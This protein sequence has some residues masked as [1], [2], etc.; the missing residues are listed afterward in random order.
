MPGRHITDSQRGLFMRTRQTDSTEVA[1]A[2][3]GFS[4]AS[5]Y[6]IA[7]DPTPPPDRR[8]SRGRRRADPLAEVFETEVVPLLEQSP[9]LRPV[10]VFRELMRRCPQLGPGVRRTLERRIRVWRAAH[11]PEKEVIFRQ[12]QEAGHLG[13]SDFTDMKGLGVLV[14]GAPLDHRLYHFR[15]PWSG[16]A[17]ARVVLGGESFSALSEGLQNALGRLGGAPREN[18]TDSLSA[19][20]RNLSKADAEDLTARYRE[21]C[22][23]YGMTPTRN[24][25]GVAHENGA[26]ESPHG[27]LKRELAD[28]LALR[29][30][31]DFGDLDA[32]RAFVSR[33]IEAANARRAG[34]I[35]AERRVL[36][37]LPPRRATDY[38]ETSV[39]VTSSGGFVLRK[40]FYTVPSRLIGHRLGVRVFDDR[41]ELFLG[42]QPHL[43]LPRG[44]RRSASRAGY[45]VNYRHVIHSLKRKPMA[46]LRSVYRDELF[47]REAYRRCFERALERGDERAAC[48]RA[49]RLLAL[50]HEANCEAE[51]AQAI[52]EDLRA[53]KLPD[54]KPLEDRFAPRCGT[55]PAVGVAPAELSGYAGLAGGAS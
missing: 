27:H 55:M 37:P 54:A 39:R 2:K 40:V 25:R 11:G 20:F 9:G 52:E 38:D 46:L 17:H 10:G 6:R 31:K 44:R 22:R 49:V 19:A 32:Y 26:I 21:V 15:L 47:P 43:T 1:A 18:R 8:Q 51:L 23:H 41:L 24:N 30:S 13:V 35:E 5:G 42:D 29:G 3:A 12:T 53:G 33:V 14:A 36:R 34:R 50:A 45:V 16:F 28:A 48:R 7:R 4:P